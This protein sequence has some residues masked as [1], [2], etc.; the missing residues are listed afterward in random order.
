MK[1]LLTTPARRP[2]FTLTELLV[3]V[4]VILTLLAIIAL[5]LPGLNQRQKTSTGADRLQG[6]LLIAKQRAKRD[7]APRGIRLLASGNPLTA[8]FVTDLQYIEAVPDLTGGTLTVN[9]PAP[10]A[11]VNL[12][13]SP[14]TVTITGGGI[15]FSTWDVQA[16]DYLEL[17][18]HQGKVLYPIQSVN[19]TVSGMPPQQYF[20]LRVDTSAALLPYLK[21]IMLAAP[22]Q[23]PMTPYYQFAV[24][25]TVQPGQIN[26]GDVLVLGQGWYPTGLPS[27]PLYTTEETVEVVDFSPPNV[28]VRDMGFTMAP[29][30]HDPM[31]NPLTATVRSSPFPFQTANYRIIR[32]PRPLLGEEPVPM[33]QDVG[34]EVP[35]C[36]LLVDPNTGGP[37]LDLLF[38]PSGA[39]LS[40]GS[41]SVG[42]GK[43]VLWVRD[44]TQDLDPATSIPQ[45]ENA[46]ITIYTR[47]GLTAAHA[48][49]PADPYRFTRE[50]RGSGL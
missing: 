26:V 44:Y 18:V 7:Q 30:S 36:Q 27:P 23:V 37:A 39:M 17:I 28:T 25:P 32:R 35:R 33:P 47:T 3:T 49:D 11:P 8:N 45:G 38:S 43:V 1:R 42:V 21:A 40:R 15:D 41:P 29:L 5:T 50:G 24:P 13:S 16:G 34:I 48:V 12:T 20:T 46:L 14:N 10:T 19:L 9:D 2:A 6:A 4:A 31:T 22:V